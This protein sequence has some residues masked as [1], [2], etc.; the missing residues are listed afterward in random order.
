MLAG[1]YDFDEEEDYPPLTVPF[2]DRA[3]D[4]VRPYLIADGGNVEVVEVEDG[5]VK[6]RL[7]GACGTCASSTA[8]MKMGIERSLMVCFSVQLHWLMHSG[9]CKLLVACL[10]RQLQQPKL[11]IGR[12]LVVCS[13]MQL[14]HLLCLCAFSQGLT[15]CV[16]RQL[17]DVHTSCK[18]FVGAMMEYQSSDV[19]YSP[20]SAMYHISH[21]MLYTHNMIV[22]ATPPL[23]PPSSAF[24]QL[25]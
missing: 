22:V 17:T 15:C 6:L 16:K 18:P 1:S 8:T 4:E 25:F 10:I 12:S 9:V 21:L 2:V 24:H 20:Q 7:Q 13:R 23:S 19:T 11:A 3:L 5:I 14:H